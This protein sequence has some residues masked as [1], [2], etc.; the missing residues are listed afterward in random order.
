ML[1]MNKRCCG[2]QGPL[3]AATAL[4]ANGW[5]LPPASPLKMQP[6]LAPLAVRETLQPAVTDAPATEGTLQSFSL[7]LLQI[8]FAVYVCACLLDRTFATSDT[9]LGRCMSVCTG[10]LTGSV[11]LQQRQ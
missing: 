8:A 9:R 11:V 3:P 5:Y 2:R 6:V 7:T 10:V 4:A 1:H